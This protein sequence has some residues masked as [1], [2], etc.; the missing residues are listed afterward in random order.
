MSVL[1]QSCSDWELIVV[2]DGST[3]GTAAIIDDFAARDSRIKA[4]HT[5]NLGVAHAR[6][7]GLKAA[8]GEWIS[9]LDS[10]DLLESDA[11]EKMLAAS[12]GF[13]LVVGNYVTF[14]E[15]KEKTVTVEKQY[16]EPGE[17]IND[18]M[19]LL[20]DSCLWT[21]WGKLFRR[22]I[23]TGEFPQDQ[24]YGEDTLF[25]LQQLKNC[26]SVNKLGTVV[27]KYRIGL[28]DSLSAQKK[29]IRMDFLARICREAESLF[30]EGVRDYMCIY[31]LRHMII[32]LRHIISC[33][34]F[35]EKAVREKIIDAISNDYFVQMP[36]KQYRLYPQEMRIFFAL[37][38]GDINLI[39][40][41]L[42]NKDLNALHER[43]NM[44]L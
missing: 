8:R 24:K 39:I 1:A 43:R 31:Y 4:V 41:E 6:N 18:G 35:D 21:V 17:M 25:M 9:F 26:R 5:A 11:L 12:D 34:E 44:D 16:H 33:K 22:G 28:D 29:N 13:D 38:C 42:M 20:M 7:A 2:D 40:H 23:I 3:D 37:K 10:D 30:G 27:Y 36:L 15:I 19:E 32:L 14:P